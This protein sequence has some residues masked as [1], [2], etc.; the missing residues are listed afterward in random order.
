MI[1]HKRGDAGHATSQCPPE[2]SGW[3][4]PAAQ[5]GTANG[6]DDTDTLPED[7]RIIRIIRDLELSSEMHGRW[8]GAL[9]SRV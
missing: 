2:T 9:P 6:R 7:Q 3:A 5:R 4:A 8:Q 1:R